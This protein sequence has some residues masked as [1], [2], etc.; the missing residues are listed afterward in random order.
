MSSIERTAVTFLHDDPQIQRRLWVFPFCVQSSEDL[1]VV[2]SCPNFAWGLGRIFSRGG[3][4]LAL[5]PTAAFARQITRAVGMGGWWYKILEAGSSPFWS[6][7]QT[8]RWIW[9]TMHESTEL[10]VVIR[11]E[12]NGLQAKLTAEFVLPSPEPSSLRRRLNHVQTSEE[13]S[14]ACGRYAEMIR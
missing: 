10:S 11:S 7:P 2:S 14:F 4:E 13:F 5:E 12:L 8:P 9:T 6:Y 1:L 3:Q